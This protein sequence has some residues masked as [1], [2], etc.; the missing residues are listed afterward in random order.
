MFS[1]QLS[2]N[3]LEAKRHDLASRVLPGKRSRWRIEANITSMKSFR[4]QHFWRR[5]S[6]APKRSQDRGFYCSVLGGFAFNTATTLY[7]AMIYPRRT[8]SK[9]SLISRQR[10]FRMGS[11]VIVIEGKCTSR[12][13]RSLWRSLSSLAAQPCN[14]FSVI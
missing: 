13:R 4:R 11:F 3:V 8:C 12:S 9:R 7:Y 14:A 2:P 1:L 10:R 5:S 6:N